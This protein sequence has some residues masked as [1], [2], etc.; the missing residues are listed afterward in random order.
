MANIEDLK[1]IREQKL[2]ALQ[3][4]GLEVYP[5]QVGDFLFVK[6]VLI[7]F[8]KL[9]QEE[10]ELALV[11]RII[12]LRPQ[13]GLIFGQIKDDSG[14]IQFFLSKKEIGEQNFDIF[15]KHLEL[16][17]IIK[18]TGKAFTTKKGEPTINTSGFVVLSKALR[19]LPEK[20]HGLQDVEKKLRYRYLEL[21][22]NDDTK[23]IFKK[24]A[25]FWDSVRSFLKEE[26][27]LEVEMPIFE[28]IP[29]GAEAEPFI[30]HYNALDKDLFLRISLEL[31]LKKLL[32]G[33]FQKV[34]EIGRVFRNEGIDSEHLQD[35][36][37]MEF[38]WAYHSLEDLKEFLQ[39]FYQFIIKK[40]LGQLEH[41]YK[42]NKINWSGQWPE[43]DYFE[44]FKKNTG[45][46]LNSALDDDLRKEIK[47]LGLKTNLDIKKIGRG[48][49]IDL[50]YKK[51]CRPNLIEPSFLV[52]HPLEISPLSKKDPQN[53][54]KV[55]RLQVVAGGSELGNGFSEL[56]DPKDQKERFLE[57]M[58]LRELG[59]KEAQMLDE[60]FIEALEYGMPPAV[61]FGFSERL[62]AFLMD[63]SIR[64]TVIFPALKSRE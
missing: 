25:L 10:K 37:Q 49:M 48:R 29:G 60:E 19:P 34:F 18:I 17:D 31:P 52:G 6:S 20:W 43:I 55:L 46:D 50:I 23:D 26:K 47:E 4:A 33:G 35:Y 45:L 22:L 53:S 57:Q 44:M 7:D 5:D 36:T 2:T 38:Y 58:K 30:T 32:V 59:D 21:L 40:T 56:N 62:F 61:G 13:G 42:G 1:R 51:T 27:F 64:E 39:K 28:D 14:K 11:G 9:Q 8:E 12:L 15:K 24:K 63:K 54:K 3:E 41:Q 16:G